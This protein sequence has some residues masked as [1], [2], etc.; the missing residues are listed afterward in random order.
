MIQ[1]TFLNYRNYRWLKIFGA[2][3]LV[4]IVAYAIDQPLGGRRGDTIIGYTYGGLA[5]AGI[6][7]LMW[8]GKRKRSYSAHLTTLR[9]CLSAHAWLGVSLAIL[10]P[11]HCGFEFGWNVHTLA[12]A[13]M[14]IVITSGVWG[15]WRYVTLAPNIESHRGGGSLI[16]QID[17]LSQ[18][19]RDLEKLCRDKSD[20]FLRMITSADF[21]VDLSLRRALLGSTIPPLDENATAAQLDDLSA[22]EQRDALTAIAI[23][24]RKREVVSSILEESATATK[25]RLWLY[26]HL[27]ISFALLVAL[28]V[29]ILSVFV[30]W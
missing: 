14:L 9:G 11:L 12:Y 4:A 3:L 30:Y 23:L 18:L 21:P 7:Y 10:V 27:P 24:K 13:L 25:M 2:L 17:V 8:Y 1:E 16:T 20:V 28:I 26:L 22:A 15:A 6:V 5:A 29:H 19:S